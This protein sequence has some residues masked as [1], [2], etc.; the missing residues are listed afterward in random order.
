MNWP[1][2]V[3]A[4]NVL[5][6]SSEKVR[7]G[8]KTSFESR[9]NIVSPTPATSTQAPPPLAVLFLHKREHCCSSTIT[10]DASSLYLLRP[11]RWGGG[12]PPPDYRLP[13]A[14]NDHAS[15]IL[16]RSSVYRGDC[17]L[18]WPHGATPA[19]WLHTNRLRSICCISQRSTSKRRHA[20]CNLAAQGVSPRLAPAT[21]PA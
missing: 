20:E 14:T 8:P 18:V 9:T 3:A 13:P 12:P 21:S 5:H 15:K 7:T 17:P 1:E 2:R 6:S 19:E 10:T 11:R 4:K 16:L